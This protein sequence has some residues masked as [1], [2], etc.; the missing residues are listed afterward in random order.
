MRAIIE[1]TKAYKGLNSQQKKITSQ[2]ANIKRI[3]NG[4]KVANYIGLEKYLTTHN[5]SH[6]NGKII[7]EIIEENLWQSNTKELATTA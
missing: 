7:K 3:D 5:P 6:N 4:V 1:N 2:L